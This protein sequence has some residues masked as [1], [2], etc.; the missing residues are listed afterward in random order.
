M[1]FSSGFIHEANRFMERGH[2]E[3]KQMDFVKIYFHKE[4]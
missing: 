2:D 1:Q 4:L 3:E